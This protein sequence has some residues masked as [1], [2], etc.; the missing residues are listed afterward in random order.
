MTGGAV[1]T[2]IIERRRLRHRP[3][4]RIDLGLQHRPE[5]RLQDPLRQR[6]DVLRDPLPDQ[7]RDEP[8]REVVAVVPEEVVLLRRELVGHVGEVL[9]DELLGQLGGAH[10][11][12][13]E[14]GAVV[15]DA[16]RRRDLD[17]LPEVVLSVAQHDRGVVDGVEVDAEEGE[18]ELAGHALGGLEGGNGQ[19]SWSCF[20]RG[21]GGAGVGGLLYL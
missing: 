5:R 8:V 15:R 4:R 14:R 6:N 12:D 17:A 11:Q 19:F 2:S 16:G 1:G 10:V 9:A 18:G 20:G 7:E 21:G 13:L 3:H